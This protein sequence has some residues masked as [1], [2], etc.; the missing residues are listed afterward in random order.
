MVETCIIPSGTAYGVALNDAALVAQWDSAFSAAPYKAPPRAPVLYVKPRSCFSV[1]GAAIPLPP[2]VPRVQ[3]AATVGLLF[4]RDLCRVRPEAVRASVGAAC[5]AL[6]VSEPCDS[7]YRPPVRQ[8]CRDGFLPMGRF[9]ALPDVFADIVTE[10]DGVEVH[11]WSLERLL[12]PL[13]RLA[14]DVSAFM[15]LGAG[16]LLL[17]G[18]AGE[19]PT[20]SAGQSIRISSLGLPALQTRVVPETA[21]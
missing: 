3:V 14:A 9:A 2:D 21:P 8:Q 6:D 17:L 12:R 18:L 7:Y 13:E 1:G 15:T 20:A 11:R 19:A 4:A 10:I 16:D 5:L